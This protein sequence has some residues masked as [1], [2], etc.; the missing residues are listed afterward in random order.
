[1]KYEHLTIG[2][3][4][5]IYEAKKCSKNQ[6]IIAREIGR[7]KSCISR[8]IR[9]NSDVVGYLYPRDAQEQARRRR[10]GK[11]LTKIE[12]DPALKAFIIDRL[13][14]QHSLHM[15][16]AQWKR[17][18]PGKK[19]SKESI[20]KFVYSNDGIALQLPRLL[21]RAKKK[22]GLERKI[23]K[24]KIKGAASIHE[25]PQ[26]INDRKELGHYE[27]DLIFNEGSMS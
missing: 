21:I 25:R 16:A 18:N 20:Y 4:I 17:Q 22:R 10:F 7:S 19:I 26:E 8:E 9:R 1:M 6:S 3:Q 13:H 24:P 23:S 14:E 12:K 27:A 2:E 5:R 11:R 15:V